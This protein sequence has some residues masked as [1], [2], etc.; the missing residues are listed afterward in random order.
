[1]ITFAVSSLIGSSAFWYGLY[2][3]A[4]RAGLMGPIDFV[5]GLVAQAAALV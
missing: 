3:L 2:D 5:E 4:Q 1:M